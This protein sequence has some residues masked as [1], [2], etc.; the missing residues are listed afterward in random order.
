MTTSAQ[1][2]SEALVIRPSLTTPLV[3]FADAQATVM[4]PPQSL[5]GLSR[6]RAL[7]ILG[8]LVRTPRLWPRSRH[9]RRPT[10][11]SGQPARE[12]DYRS[13]RTRT[14]CNC[15][16]SLSPFAGHLLN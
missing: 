16:S 15:R 8:Q 9:P 2:D 14:R 6:E 1:T 13:T 11:P 5:S 12:S 3:P 4:L 7:A 10:Q